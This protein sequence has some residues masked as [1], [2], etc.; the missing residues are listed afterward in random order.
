MCF[1]EPLTS[2]SP[3]EV[4][5]FFWEDAV[6]LLSFQVPNSL[7]PRNPPFF[8]LLGA[9]TIDFAIG[10][11]CATPHTN[12]RPLVISTH[13]LYVIEKALGC[14]NSRFCVWKKLE[15]ASVT[16]SSI[17]SLHHAGPHLIVLLGG[18]YDENFRHS[19]EQLYVLRRA[20]GTTFLRRRLPNPRW[21]DN[22]EH[23]ACKSVLS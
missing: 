8:L 17:C 5:C 21:T 15:P 23:G 3:A 11:H 2:A 4:G 6:F 18:R 12:Q 20:N 9:A 7:R 10:W 16:V 22:R 19:R 1:S 14:Y 13:S